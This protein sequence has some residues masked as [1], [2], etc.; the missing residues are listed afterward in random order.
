MVVQC[1]V[2]V[3]MSIWEDEGDARTRIG[4]KRE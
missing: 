3:H 1:V 4:K 2:R